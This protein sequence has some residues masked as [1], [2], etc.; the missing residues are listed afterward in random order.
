MF[1]VDIFIGA[2]VNDVSIDPR[3]KV[4]DSGRYSH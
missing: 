2:I 1:T 4:V 3:R